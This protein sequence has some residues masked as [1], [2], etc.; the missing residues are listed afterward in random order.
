VE[1]SMTRDRSVSLFSRGDIDFC[2]PMA[3]SVG[4]APLMPPELPK[5]LSP[6]G[7][8]MRELCLKSGNLCA[9]PG[10]RQRMMDA[11][12]RFIG[13]VCHIEA[14][15][16]EGERFNPSMTNEQRRHVSNLLLMCYPHHTVTNDV[17]AYPVPK[18]RRLKA[19]HE[20]RFTAPDSTTLAA[21]AGLKD[22]TIDVAPTTVHSLGRL[23]ATLGWSPSREE[24]AFCV[25]L[26]NRF[27]ES[28]QK[29]PHV[30]R[31]FI[32]LVA[33]RIYRMRDTR[34]VVMS[35]FSGTRIL[36]SDLKGALRVHEDK[37]WE[38]GGQLDTYKLGRMDEME[39]DVGT[40]AA[41]MVRDLDGWEMWVDLARFSANTSVQMSTFTL[42]LDFGCLD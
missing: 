10:C 39:T 17:V 15:E 41:V 5:R 38:L 40:Q 13:Q 11:D 35:P 8:A 2:C 12:G 18:L 25:G 30:V 31:H 23:V 24:A 34:A 26:L 33:E 1:F 21:L 29:V 4:E 7:K 19:E 20:Q 28:F 9:F 32:G 27:T 3:Q 16:K 42:D 37:I 6:T 14:A 36:V 22:W